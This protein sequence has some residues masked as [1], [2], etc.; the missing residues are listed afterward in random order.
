MEKRRAELEEEHKKLVELRNTATEQL[1]RIEG[2]LLLL[3]E[4]E[5]ATQAEPAETEEAVG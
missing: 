3:R 5:Q 4:L 2:A 1:L